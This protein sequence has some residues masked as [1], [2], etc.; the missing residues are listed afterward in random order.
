MGLEFEC[1][2]FEE[3]PLFVGKKEGLLLVASRWAPS[4]SAANTSVIGGRR[5]LVCVAGTWWIC[6]VFER[7]DG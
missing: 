2:E 6:D 3:E 5:L 4:P 7:L 1:E